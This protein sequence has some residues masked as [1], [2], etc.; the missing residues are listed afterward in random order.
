MSTEKNPNID[1]IVQAAVTQAVNLVRQ[2][3][4]ENLKSVRAAYDLAL[5][6]MKANH[7]AS[8][9]SFAASADEKTTANA[10]LMKDEV[11]K[12]MAEYREM[13]K[14]AANTTVSQIDSA[15]KA[16]IAEVARANAD[17]VT[18]VEEAAKA[19]ADADQRIMKAEAAEEKATKA[20]ERNNRALEML[21]L[22]R[23]AAVQK[24]ASEM[25]FNQEEKVL[26]EELKERRFKLERDNEARQDHIA[27]SIRSFYP[28]MGQRLEEELTRLIGEGK[29][30]GQED[31]PAKKAASR[32]KR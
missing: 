30:P 6:D 19:K 28:E 26:L 10:H 16:S 14:S 24:V 23:D 13:W 27:N 7:K 21:N 4:T 25:I 3:S 17:L 22:Q 11:G 18:R 29:I 12:V 5:K 8:L 1:A 32:P 9:D 15:A 31:A 20:E 2:E